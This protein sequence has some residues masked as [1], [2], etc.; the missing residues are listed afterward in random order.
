MSVQI[1]FCGYCGSSIAHHDLNDSAHTLLACTV[2]G[3]A[4]SLID[5]RRS[6]ALLVLIQ[7]FAEDRMLLMKRGVD[8]YKGQWAPP[9]GFVESGES[10]ETA[11]IREAWEEV[12]IK[13]DRT[14][15]L[16]TLSSAF[17]E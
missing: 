7:V 4:S 13:L 10:L 12:C 15:L 14:Q 9:G 1:K 5:S 16:P 11:A 17:Q 6:P 3:N 2:C 8:P